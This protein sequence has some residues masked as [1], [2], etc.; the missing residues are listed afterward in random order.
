MQISVKTCYTKHQ[1]FS[2][3]WPQILYFSPS[4][5]HYLINIMLP[6]FANKYELVQKHKIWE[7][8]ILANIK[9]SYFFNQ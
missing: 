5:L 2:Q 8:I 7:E 6:L 1:L 3:S 4:T 9:N